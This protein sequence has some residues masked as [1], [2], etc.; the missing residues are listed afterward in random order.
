MDTRTN[1][2]KLSRRQFLR[3]SATVLGAG[4]VSAC[5]STPTSAPAPKATGAPAA[6]PTAI[7]Q[8]RAQKATV[9]MWT[10]PFTP[11]TS[12]YEPMQ[13]AF[14][15]ANPNIDVQVQL[16]PWAGRENKMI[17]A[18]AAGNPP[19]AVYLNPDFYPKF[20]ATE[21]VI[22]LDKFMPAGFRDDFLPGALSAVSYNNQTYG[23]PILTSAYTE[24]YNQELIEAAGVTDITTNWDTFKAAVR[25]VHNPAKEIWGAWFD[26]NRPSPVST[27]VPFLRMAG[28]DQFTADGKDIAFDKPEG[29]EA[30]EY[31][32]S[33]YKEGLVQKANATG[34]GLPFSSGKIGFFMQM[35][36]GSLV[37]VRTANPNM[38]LGIPPCLKHKEQSNFGTVGSFGVFKLSK[39]QE[40]AAKWLAFLTNPENSLTILK[41]SG[42]LSARKSITPEKYAEGI[43]KD[44][45][46]QAPLMRSEPQHFYSREVMAAQQPE[47]QA[48]YL[49]EQSAKDAITKSAA[50]ARKIL[51]G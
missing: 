6:A 42:F 17:A 20:V 8:A 24:M 14:T 9:L 47:F 10:F 48:A 43:V 13:K 41:A 40:A 22:P 36:T 38:K 46:V 33:F 39:N 3:A 2:K 7:P 11:D 27:F 29:V 4:V 1:G 26:L 15:A 34:G 51:A 16:E 37:S 30:L 35:E 12:V 25:K 28:G 23:L 49:G 44:I 31:L 19:D 45:A 32:T 18:V 5:A 21:T 50:A